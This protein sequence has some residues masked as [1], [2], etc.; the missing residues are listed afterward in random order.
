MAFKAFLD[1]ESMKK[2]RVLDCEFG[3]TQSIDN[4]GKPTSRPRGST[5]KLVL[6]S[7]NDLELV[8]WMFSHSDTK[9]GTIS[10]LR[11]DNEAAM[12]KLSFKDGICISYHESFTDYGNTPMTTTIVISAREIDIDGVV[13]VNKWHSD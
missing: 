8:S 13:L 1:F 10:F 12:K 7:T 2:V 11:R 6:E 3:F 4:T 9:D 5:I